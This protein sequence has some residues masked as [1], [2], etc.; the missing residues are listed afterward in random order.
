MHPILAMDP[1]TGALGVFTLQ[2]LCGTRPSRIVP[3]AQILLRR[4]S[5]LYLDALLAEG[6]DFAV[7]LA[8]AIPVTQPAV[9]ALLALLLGA[10]VVL[11]RARAR[12]T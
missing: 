3:R 2:S 11:L 8:N 10:F 1:I 5:Q 12:L 4:N 6:S 9:C 7:D